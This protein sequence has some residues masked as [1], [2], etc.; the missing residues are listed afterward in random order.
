MT[1]HLGIPTKLTTR[2]HP[3]RAPPFPYPAH[4]EARSV[5]IYVYQREGR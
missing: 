2:H 1:K 5:F 3:I 4:D